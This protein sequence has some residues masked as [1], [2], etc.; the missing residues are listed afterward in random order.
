MS[1]DQFDPSSVGAEHNDIDSAQLSPLTQAVQI[2]DADIAD[3]EL[4]QDY[5]SL[6]PSMSTLTGGIKI[7]KCRRDEFVH[8]HADDPAWQPYRAAVIKVGIGD[9]FVLHSKLV[10]QYCA[11]TDPMYLFPMINRSGDI[12]LWPIRMPDECGELHEW[13]AKALE[14]QAKSQTSWIRIMVNRDRTNYHCEFPESPLS[15]PV[16]PRDIPDMKTLM[17]IVLR[18]VLITTDDHPVLR[19]RLARDGNGK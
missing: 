13:N 14:A 4:T 19:K 15:E 10:P 8:G 7:R 2:S 17:R 5:G 9:Y 11:E 1:Q 12:F 6:T 18:K 16:W 3:A